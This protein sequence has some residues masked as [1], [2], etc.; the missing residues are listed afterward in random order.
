MCEFYFHTLFTI[1]F[2]IRNMWNKF[3]NCSYY[4]NISKNISFYLFLM[5]TQYSLL[6]WHK[7]TKIYSLN[8]PVLSVFLIDMRTL[9]RK[10]GEN[11]ICLLT[12]SLKKCL[13][14]LWQYLSLSLSLINWLIYKYDNSWAYKSSE[15]YF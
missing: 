13:I 14:S 5:H 12:R 4:Y 8:N 2:V 1:K 11:K 9:L 3:Y 7:F 6:K 10:I 15:K